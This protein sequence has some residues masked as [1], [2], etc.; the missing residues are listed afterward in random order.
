MVPLQVSGINGDDID[1]LEA[2]PDKPSVEVGPAVSGLEMLQVGAAGG[3]GDKSV[4][5]TQLEAL[6]CVRTLVGGTPVD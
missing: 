2:G 4:H 1:P 5:N 3:V 6:I